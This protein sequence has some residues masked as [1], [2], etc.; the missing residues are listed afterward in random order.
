MIP[1]LLHLLTEW[2]LDSG[3]E[4]WE[5]IDSFLKEPGSMGSDNMFCKGRL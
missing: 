2:S 5:V 4:E 3:L 1:P